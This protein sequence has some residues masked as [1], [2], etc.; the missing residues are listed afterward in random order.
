M[1]TFYNG[2]TNA[3]RILV[4]VTS[5]GS[6]IGKNIEVACELL[7]QMASNAYQCTLECNNLKKVL[8]VHELNV[9]TTLSS[10]VAI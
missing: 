2:L 6:V 8:G 9:L 10:Q 4:G 1:Q 3:T 7:E 5:G